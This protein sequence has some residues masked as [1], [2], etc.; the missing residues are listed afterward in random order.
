MCE[1]CVWKIMEE[2]A[3]TIVV[4]M[5][6]NGIDTPEKIGAFIGSCGRGFWYGQC[7][8]NDSCLPFGPLLVVTAAGYR[9][10]WAVDSFGRAMLQLFTRIADR[11]KI[12][13]IPWQLVEQ[14]TGFWRGD[15][16]HV[17]EQGVYTGW[18]VPLL[19][20]EHERDQLLV[21]PTGGVAQVPN[22]LES[23]Q[24]VY[25][26]PELRYDYREISKK[27]QEGLLSISAHESDLARSLAEAMSAELG[28]PRNL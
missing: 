1:S 18:Q 24:I 12:I 16:H 23:G 4:R 25:S 10:E 14:R 22:R 11:E 21:S 7:D 13:R 17:V 19:F 2:N 5:Q 28:L 9:P 6:Q 3:E 20:Q 26:A 15:Y 8:W 27:L